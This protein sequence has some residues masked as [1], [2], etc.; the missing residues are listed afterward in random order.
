MSL[1]TRVLPPDEWPKLAGT[2]LAAM[3]GTLREALAS[4]VVVERDG[5]I[6][7]CWALVPALTVHG[8]WIH[9]DQR[10][11]RAGWVLWQAMKDLVRSRGCRAVLTTAQSPD[12]RELLTH[13][14]ATPIGEEYVLPCEG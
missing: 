6:V 12:V 10:K 4:V 14:G 3:T 8:L 2:D 1:T 7:G 11:S 9:P 5:V 13:V